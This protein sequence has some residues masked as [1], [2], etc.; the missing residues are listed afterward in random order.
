MTTRTKQ[1]N[2]VFQYLLLLA[3]L[4]GMVVFQNSK[5]LNSNLSL[6]VMQNSKVLNSN[7]SLVAFQN[8]KVEQQPQLGRLSGQQGF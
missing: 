6:V 3:I 7:L 5:V 2:H 4:M 8:S 1:K